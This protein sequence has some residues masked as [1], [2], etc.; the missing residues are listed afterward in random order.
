MRRLNLRLGLWRPATT[1]ATREESQM[2]TFRQGDIL[3]IPVG[4]IPAEARKQR[5]QRGR[6]ILAEGE[7]T[8]HAH[9]VVDRGADLY[10]LISEADVA[11]MRQR[12]LDVATEVALVHDEHATI[13]VPPGRYEVRRQREYS[14]EAIRQVSD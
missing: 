3:L 13:A 7:A 8:G 5:R 1:N 2:D 9:A 12:F 4:S 10:E 14:P 6:L 11:E